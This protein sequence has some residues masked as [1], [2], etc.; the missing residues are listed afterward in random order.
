MGAGRTPF[1]DTKQ[2]RAENG[3]IATP[4]IGKLNVAV[5]LVDLASQA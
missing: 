5:A 1:N 3:Q 4:P 2:C